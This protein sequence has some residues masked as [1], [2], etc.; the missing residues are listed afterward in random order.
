MM[1]RECGACVHSHC[2]V[3]LRV[4]HIAL[5]VC[6]SLISSSKRLIVE[7]WRWQAERVVDTSTKPKADVAWASAFKLGGASTKF[8]LTCWNTPQAIIYAAAICSGTRRSRQADCEAT[9]NCMPTS[10]A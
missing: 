3:A 2:Y 8:G 5:R 7:V 1:S 9:T 4:Q 6:S 10:L